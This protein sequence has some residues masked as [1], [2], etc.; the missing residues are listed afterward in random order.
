MIRSTRAR[1]ADT[2]MPCSVPPRRM[3]PATA[4]SSGG[5]P[6]ATSF[7][8]ELR[9]PSG[10]SLSVAR[11]GS[12]AT[13][14]PS[15]SATAQAS[16]AHP[17]NLVHQPGAAQFLAQCLGSCLCCWPRRDLHVRERREM[18][19]SPR[20]YLLRFDLYSPRQNPLCAV[21]LAELF[22]MIHAVEQRH[23]DAIA[24]FL[25]RYSTKCRLKRRCFD[26]DPHD[27][28]LSIEQI[29]DLHRCLESSEHLTLDAQPPGIVIPAASPYE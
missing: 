6:A 7:C 21:A 2:S 5:R 26:G 9:K 18:T 27:I 23:E 13:L 29:R 28:K 15:E 20:P 10:A 24:Q 22:D 1:V 12:G 16:L 19:N 17:S 4:S 3:G 8:I 11:I 25:R 14:A